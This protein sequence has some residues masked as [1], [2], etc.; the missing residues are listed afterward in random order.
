VAFVERLVAQLDPAASP[1][2]G[3]TEEH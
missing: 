3:E 2:D 1:A